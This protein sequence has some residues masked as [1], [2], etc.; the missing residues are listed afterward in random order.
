MPTA[1]LAKG[2]QFFESNSFEIKS[3]TMVWC[4][5]PFE[6]LSPE[7]EAQQSELVSTDE[8]KKKE[9]EKEDAK[10]ELDEDVLVSGES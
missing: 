2:K 9:T 7:E 1:L 6:P 4:C 5:D 10:E 8:K 3:N